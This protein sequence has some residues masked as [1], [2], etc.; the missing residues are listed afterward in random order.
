MSAIHFDL[1]KRIS[2]SSGVPGFEK[3]IRELI[4][5]ELEGLVDEIKVDNMGNILATK[6]GRQDKKVMVS[7][8]MD[9]IGF[10]VSYIDD[11]GYCRFQPLG[12][13]DP[14]TLTSQRVLVHGKEKVVGVMGSKPVHIMSPEEK[15]KSPQLKDYFIDLGMK[16]DKVEQKISIGSPVTRLRSLI[17]MGDC[18]NGKS[19]DN[20]VSVYILLETLRELKDSTLPYDFVAAFT[21]QEEVGL[22]GAIS[23]AHQVNP[24]FGINLDVT[25]AFD[26][27]GAQAHESVTKLGKGTAIKIMDGHTI[28]DYRMVDYLKH[29]A[30]REMITYQLEILPAGGTDTAAL[31][32]SGK[33][34]SIA[35]AISIPLR[36]M[37]S[38]IEMV[39]KNDIRASIELLKSAL[40]TLDKYDWSH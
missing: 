18:V 2:E 9:E 3:E 36:N 17:E 15:T 26:T 12:G 7:A 6:K 1:L 4:V 32:K 37:H 34:G 38:V 35:G 20:R 27:P 16:K 31:Q 8:H 24:D 5:K 13:F 21:V 25:V 22:R 23:A 29:V 39:D 10:I 11:E 40:E 28:C 14:K 19:L 33:N 30:E